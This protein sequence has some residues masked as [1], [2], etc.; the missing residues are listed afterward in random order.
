M[1][2]R[3]RPR[4]PRVPWTCPPS[5]QSSN[6]NST[7]T[8]SARELQSAQLGPDPALSRGR[9]GHTAIAEEGLSPLRTA[10]DLAGPGRVGPWPIPTAHE[11]SSTNVEAYAG[12]CMLACTRHGFCHSTQSPPLA[13]RCHHP[14]RHLCNAIQS[15]RSSPLC[16]AV[17]H[18]G[19]APLSR[20]AGVGPGGCS[21]IAESRGVPLSQ[22]VP[23]N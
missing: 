5:S 21:A 22:R 13:S 8:F 11:G 7:S 19:G 9:P 17:P 1:P 20:G 23:Q 14:P 16:N 12:S 3:W 10:L 15:P 18:W 2:R 4:R 6:Y